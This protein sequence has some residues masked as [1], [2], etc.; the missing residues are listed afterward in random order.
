MVIL[1]GERCWRILNVLIP[2]L[3]FQ[4]FLDPGDGVLR[5]LRDDC[6]CECDSPPHG[7]GWA[8]HHTCANWREIIEAN[9]SRLQAQNQGFF[10]LPVE[11]IQA[12]QQAEKH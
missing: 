6:P 12:V 4:T 8:S 9:A 10:V 5:K 2:L 3:Q 7:L 1:N 11:Q